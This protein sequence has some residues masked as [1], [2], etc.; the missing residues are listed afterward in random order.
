MSS[1]AKPVIGECFRGL[2]YREFTSENNDGK[3]IKKVN[4]DGG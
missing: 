1:L 4:K 2:H 3:N